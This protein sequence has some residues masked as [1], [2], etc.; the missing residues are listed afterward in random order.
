MIALRRARKEGAALPGSAKTGGRIGYRF[1]RCSGGLEL[2]R[3]V[4]SGSENETLKTT[5]A[6]I[7]SGRVDGPRFLATQTDLAVE[8]ILGS[9]LHGALPRG[10]VPRL[11]AALADCPNVQLDG[12]PVRTSGERIGLCARLVDAD[13]GF[14][15]SVGRDPRVTEVIGVDTVLC[16]DTL[17]PVGATNLT[18]R[19]LDELTR[20]R[21]FGPGDVADLVT[22]I[23]PSLSQRIPVDVQ[24]RRLPK[25]V[26]ETAAPGH[27]GPPRRRG[28][29]GPPDP[30]L[31]R[32]PD[33]P[34]R[35]RQ[36]R[37][38]PRPRAAARRGRA[39]GS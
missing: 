22:E 18:G 24:T 19:E 27:R 5:L 3:V 4:I 17:H 38:A 2:D 35:R 30:G 37:L 33:R 15:L 29:L 23:L 12:V 34:R 28:A 11:L 1:R 9:R 32:S 25:T 6:A 13:G 39:S 21:T 7:A 20:G 16:G 8:R 36:A 10:I 31:R 26:K 14:R